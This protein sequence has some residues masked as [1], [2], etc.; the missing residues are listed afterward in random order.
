[1]CAID[2][3]YDGGCPKCNPEFAAVMRMNS[4][5]LSEW[6]RKRTAEMFRTTMTRRGAKKPLYGGQI[7]DATDKL[8]VAP[9]PSLAKVEAPLTPTQQA[10]VDLFKGK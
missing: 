5:Q 8:P 6:N 1:M 10:I 4:A 9:A 7:G 2:G 3:N